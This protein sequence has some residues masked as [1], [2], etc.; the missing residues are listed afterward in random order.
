MSESIRTFK[1]H[2]VY[3]FY[4]FFCNISKFDTLTDNMLKF[5]LRHCNNGL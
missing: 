3:L 1:M 4:L 2:Y 5:A